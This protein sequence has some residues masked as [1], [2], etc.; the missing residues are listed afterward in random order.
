MVGDVVGV[1]NGVDCDDVLGDDGADDVGVGVD[2]VG[3]DSLSSS[4]S[5]VAK[6][7]VDYELFFA[8]IKTSLADLNP[9][10]ILKFSL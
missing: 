10:D 1:V 7:A 2:I 5:A 9:L 8:P 3:V 6:F 4:S